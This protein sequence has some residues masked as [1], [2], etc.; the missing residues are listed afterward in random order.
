MSIKNSNHM[1][2]WLRKCLL[3]SLCLHIFLLT[4]CSNRAETNTDN[5]KIAIEKIYEQNI[6]ISTSENAAEGFVLNNFAGNT[7]LD[8]SLTLDS[9]YRYFCIYVE[10]TSSDAIT[11]S[12][13]NDF[14]TE[15]VFKCETGSYCIW[16][17]SEWNEGK[18]KVSFGS[19]DGLY[20]KA[21]GIRCKEL[22][23]M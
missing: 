10:N 13:E 20:G 3:I 9:E 23:D 19:I 21:K 12:I 1:K 17:T 2:M 16:S 22:E 11:V 8:T 14:G 6:N 4:G 7:S 5:S 18:Y 15:N